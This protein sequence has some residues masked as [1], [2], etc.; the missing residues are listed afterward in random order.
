MQIML[1]QD[2]DLIQINIANESITGH[3]Y[4]NPEAEF[5]DS[6][7]NLLTEKE[8]HWWEQINT[9]PRALHLSPF[10]GPP[11]EIKMGF[12]MGRIRVM[13]SLIMS[14]YHHCNLPLQMSGPD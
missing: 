14:Q 7:D 2:Q 8:V 12:I 10:L 5:P 4:F 1:N 6:L 9:T 13:S 3:M 11:K